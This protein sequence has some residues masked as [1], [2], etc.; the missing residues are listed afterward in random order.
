MIKH[1]EAGRLKH[2]QIIAIEFFFSLPFFS[3][4]YLHLGKVEQILWILYM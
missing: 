3:C 2:H 1:R 4:V